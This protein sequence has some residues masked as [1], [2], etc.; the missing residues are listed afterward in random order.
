MSTPD[1]TELAVL[2]RLLWWGGARALGFG[3]KIHPNPACRNEPARPS[4]FRHHCRPPSLNLTVNTSS[5]HEAKEKPG[6]IGFS[7]P[8]SIALCTTFA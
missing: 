7:W 3:G 5:C 4:V 2:Q 6:T 1:W 8:A